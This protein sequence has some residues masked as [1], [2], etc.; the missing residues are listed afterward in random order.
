MT[1][2]MPRLMVNVDLDE[3]CFV[4]PEGK[5]IA[6]IRVLAM[7]PG[8]LV[9]EAAYAYNQARAAPRLFE[10]TAEDAPEFARKLV[11]AVQRAQTTHY[12]SEA[13]KIAINVVANGYVLQIGD[14]DNTREIYL[15]T[16]CIWRVCNGLLRAID[17]VSP[18][19]S[20]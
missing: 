4:F 11:D 12:V 7:P 13:T 18:S 15:S 6:Q 10:L 16:G 3:R 19:P 5:N 9:I 14:V 2:H 1:I 8:D 20:H 17:Q